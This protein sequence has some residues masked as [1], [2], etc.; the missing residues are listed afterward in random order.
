[1]PTS[2]CCVVDDA[3]DEVRPTSRLPGRL[4]QRPDLRTGASRR[5]FAAHPHAVIT[6]RSRRAWWPPVRS[7][8]TRHAGTNIAF[9]RLSPVARSGWPTS[10]VDIRGTCT[11]CGTRRR[12]GSPTARTV[13][14]SAAQHRSTAEDWAVGVVGAGP[15]RRRA[16]RLGDVE[17]LRGGLDID[18]V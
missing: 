5:V 8:A 14:T 4:E 2:R 12:R 18:T 3:T 16:A 1:M 10:A 17:D 13:S 15:V 9:R 7:T 11:P 6:F